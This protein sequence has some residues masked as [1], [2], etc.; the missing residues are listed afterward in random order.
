MRRSAAIAI[1]WPIWCG[2]CWRTAPTPRSSSVAADP[3][4]RSTTSCKRPQ[5]WIGDAAHARHPHIPLPRDLY[6]PERR[7]SAGVEFGDRAALDALLAEVAPR[8][9]RAAPLIDGVARAARARG[10][11]PIDGAHRHVRSRRGVVRRD[12]GGA[13]AF[14]PGPRRRSSSAR[15]RS[16]APPICSRR[17]AAR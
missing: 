2:G 11:S 8:R 10:A 16:N 17:R 12:G 3:A 7:N 13:A 14:P 4:C 5:A 9:A 1:C 15:R 6:R